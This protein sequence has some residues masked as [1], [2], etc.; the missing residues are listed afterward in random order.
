MLF[1]GSLLQLTF[2]LRGSGLVG[3]RI[4]YIPCLFLLDEEGRALLRSEPILDVIELFRGRGEKYLRLRTPIRFDFDPDAATERHPASHM[5]L[6][7]PNCRIPVRGPLGL[8]HFIK[9]VFWHF[10]PTV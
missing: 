7:H 9:F 2:D 6:N 10:Y 3:H 1:D 8:G 4:G 5:T